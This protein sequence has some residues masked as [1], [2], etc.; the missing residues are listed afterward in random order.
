V[1]GG[2]WVEHRARVRHAQQAQ[3]PILM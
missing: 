2:L 1:A 3:Q